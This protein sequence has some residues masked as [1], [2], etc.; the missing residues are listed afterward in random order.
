MSSR[1]EPGSLLGLQ[2]ENFSYPEQTLPTTLLSQTL[3]IPVYGSNSQTVHVTPPGRMQPTGS[4]AINLWD[5]QSV[6]PTFSSSDSQSE[7]NPP[8]QFSSVQTPLTQPSTVTYSQTGSPS[9]ERIQ[10]RRNYERIKERSRRAESEIERLHEVNRGNRDDI[11]QADGILEELM[12]SENMPGEMYE[13]LM[14]VS[15]LLERVSGRIRRD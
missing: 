8:A 4:E 11:G 5:T 2:S 9:T 7:T 10:I 14:D 1:F 12:D 15:R 3:S 6:I 13:K